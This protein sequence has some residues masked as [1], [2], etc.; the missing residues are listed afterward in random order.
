M[1][2]ISVVFFVLLTSLL[3]GMPGRSELTADTPASLVAIKP[4]LR[5]EI[6]ALMPQGMTSYDISVTIPDDDLALGQTIEGQQTVIYTN[7][8]D[9]TIGALPFRLYANSIGALTPPLVI[10]S[11]QIGGQDAAI[12]YS[13][14][15]SVATV[16][17]DQALA[18]GDAVTIE[19][20]FSLAVPVD[21]P[22]HYGI[23]NYDTDSRTAVMA[24]WY[25][26]VAG[27][28]PNTGWMLDPVSIFG[29]PI[30]TDAG[31]YTVT[32]SAPSN[33]QMITSGV[34]TERV[35]DSGRSTVTFEASPSRD[36]V[37]ITSET[38][39]SYETEVD[40]TTIT[41]WTR[42]DNAAV[43]PQVATW[44]ANALEVFN[45]LLGEYPWTQLQVIQAPIYSAAAVELP[46]MFIMGTSFYRQA[47]D[48]GS[49]FEF[50]VAHEA[51][52]M[53]FY[54]QVG[55]NQYAHAFIDEGLTNYL[56]ADIYFRVMYG[57]EFGDTT[58]QR[59]L[60][61]DFRRMIESNADVIVDF[62]T[63]AFPTAQ[64]Y[65]NAV[66]TKAPLGFAAIH[67]AMGDEAFFAAL[68]DYVDAF[69]FRV[70][71][72]A[73]LEAAFQHHTDVVIREIWSHWFE[74]REGA[75]DIRSGA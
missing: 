23:L 64:S 39:V 28:D 5:A 66:Y 52:H 43:S 1:R 3:P 67:E 70:A 13:V 40:G 57:D 55:N 59:F 9:E 27:R 8:T 25:P 35:D 50:T 58:R 7:V 46:Q 2:I 21:D 54:S 45:P 10:N 41:S 36:F 65:V 11:A 61:G 63:D 68:Q 53:W 72:P 32:V 26:V 29:D 20:T 60:V 71:R 17:L 34:E 18:P 12:T 74:R 22:T 56:S 38:L 44:T 49:Y 62:P 48:T 4:E 47:A 69:R 6:A 51:V 75:L 42:P 15:D 30:F 16:Q 31:L 24:H 37:I 19:M 14:H 73:D 33:Q